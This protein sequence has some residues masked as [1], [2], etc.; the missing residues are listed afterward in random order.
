MLAVVTLTLLLQ[1]GGVNSVPDSYISV[2]QQ[3]T[4][5]IKSDSCEALKLEAIKIRLEGYA[6]QHEAFDLKNEALDLKEEALQIR[7]TSANSR[8][9]LESR[10][11]ETL[12]DTFAFIK[13]QTTVISL[14]V[15]EIKSTLSAVQDKINEME[16]KFEKQEEKF[17]KLEEKFEKLEEKVEQKFTDLQEQNSA[18]MNGLTDQG[19]ALE[20]QT[21]AI[22]EQKA[23]I[24]E[25]TTQT[26]SMSEDVSRT[27]TVTLTLKSRQQT[28]L[29]EVRLISLYKPTGQTSTW[30]GPGHESELAS[31]GLYTFSEHDWAS[32][33]TYSHTGTNSPN[34]KIWLELGGWFKIHKVKVWNIRHCCL[35]RIVGS[36]VLADTKLIGTITQAQSSYDFTVAEE[37]PTYARKVTLHQPLGQ[38]LHILELQVWGSGPFPEQD[39]FA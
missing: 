25:Q 38:W 12:V 21:A 8:S 13:S 4:G 34:N 30:A 37:D 15:N 6:A 5:V 16:E 26:A 35:E 3:D 24:E 28:I 29:S 22:E 10:L 32:M 11:V 19:A 14:H 23:A 18:I 2:P 7:E 20:T 31:D 33:A 36:I 9:L 27:L 17:E 39:K 1:I